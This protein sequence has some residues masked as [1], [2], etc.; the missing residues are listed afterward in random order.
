MKKYNWEEV[1]ERYE[2]G[3]SFRDLCAE[4]GMSMYDIHKAKKRGDFKSRSTSEAA[5]LSKKLKPQKHSEETK[6]KIS[7][8]R[9]KFL[10]ENP[11][12]VPYLLNHYS[13]GMSYPEKYFEKAFRNEN[14]NL[15]YHYRIGTYELDFSDPIRKIDI[16][17]D[18]EQH[19]VDKKIVESDKR[20]NKYLKDRGWIVYRVRWS[21]FVR[22]TKD[23]RKTVVQEIKS[24][25]SNIKISESEIK[26]LNQK[27][28]EISEERYSNRKIKECSVC[29][30]KISKSAN[31]CIKCA[32]K[33]KIGKYRKVER[34]TKEELEKL[35]NSMSWVAI[36]R[37]YNVS[38]NAVRKWARSYGIEW[39]KRKKSN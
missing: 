7:E 26:K 16:E 10:K 4:F 9:K 21:H 13:K 14:I 2:E 12:K 37:K 30:I 24:L 29:S 20:R 36:G 17:I 3:K 15:V 28:L 19:Y 18:G 32:N 23:F 35:I 27:I 31:K 8:A 5:K 25:V 34:P 1:Q 11:D 33:E 6:K 38:D 22:L 39:K